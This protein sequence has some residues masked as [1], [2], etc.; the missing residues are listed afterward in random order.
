MKNSLFKDKNVI[1]TGHV[2]PDG[3]CVGS[4]LGLYY[5]IKHLTKSCKVLLPAEGLKQYMGFPFTDDIIEAKY[6]DPP[7]FYTLVCVDCSDWAR[8]AYPNLIDTADKV[9]VI[10]HHQNS[11]FGEISFMIE[12]YSSAGELVFDLFGAY[13]EAA[14][15]HL[16]YAILS[17]TQRLTTSATTQE[18]WQKVAKLSKKAGYYLDDV[19]ATITKETISALRLKERAL[20]SMIVE[21]NSVIMKLEEKDFIECRS[22]KNEVDDVSRMLNTIAGVTLGVL[23]YHDTTTGKTKASFRSSGSRTALSLASE[24]GGG[25]HKHAAGATMEGLTVTEAFDKLRDKLQMIP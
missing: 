8:V 24:F 4:C 23:V 3:D 9:I 20:A 14:A 25:G 2:N 16:L 11:D 5:N 7:G 6:Y 17:D 13:D 12:D 15:A 21:K 18:T 22:S 10:D 19:N 1:I